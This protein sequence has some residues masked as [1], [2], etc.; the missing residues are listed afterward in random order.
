MIEPAAAKFEWG[1]RVVSIADM[2]NDGSFPGVA[3]GELLVPAG[4]AGEVVRTGLHVDSGT[5]VYMVE[6]DGAKVIGCLEHEIALSNE[7]PTS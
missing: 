3:E 2:F 1:Q 5:H 7:S 6:F 4:A